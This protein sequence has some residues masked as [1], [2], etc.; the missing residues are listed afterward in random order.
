VLKYQCDNCGVLATSTVPG[1]PPSGWLTLTLTVSGSYAD[2]AS[3]QVAP[4]T[5][6]LQAHQQSCADALRAGFVAKFVG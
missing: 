6:Q 1:T 3:Q 4:V 5:V 2:Q